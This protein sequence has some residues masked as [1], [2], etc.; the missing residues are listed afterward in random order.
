[1][2]EIMVAIEMDKIKVWQLAKIGYVK[3]LECNDYSVKG[4]LVN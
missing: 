2:S 3:L 4:I 1:M